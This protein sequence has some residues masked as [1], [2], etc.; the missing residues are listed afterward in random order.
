LL[1]RKAIRKVLE[2]ISAIGMKG[3]AS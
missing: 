1:D 3:M 2:S